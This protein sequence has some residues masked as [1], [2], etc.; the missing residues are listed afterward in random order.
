MKLSEQAI[1]HPRIIYVATLLVCMLSVLAMI[2][3]PVQR[4]P[5]ISKAVVLVAVP[6]PGAQPTEVEEQITRKIEETLQKLDRVDFVSS[7]SM[8]GSSVTQVVFLDGVD[9]EAA[10]GRV[11]DLVDEV[12]RELPGGRDVEP[13]VTDIDFENAPLMLVNMVPPEDFDERSLKLLAEEVQEELEAVEGVSSTQLFGGREREIHVDLNVDLAMEHGVAIQDVRNALAAYNSNL[14]G[15]SL[16]TGNVDFQVRSATKFRSLDDI[17]DAVVRSDAGRII[18][19]SDIASVTDTYR[20]L[21]NLAHLDGSDCATIIVY[22]ESDINT[23]QTAKAVK[24]RVE[25]LKSQYPQLQFSTTRDTSEEI[26]VMF[27]V[28]GSSFVF[29]AMLV[30][31][32]LGWAM[33]LRMS[34]LVLT[35]VPLSSGIALI[36][37]FA[38][39]IPISNMVIFSFI[40]VLG[41]VVDGAI[42][43]AENIHRH[44]EL[45]KT[46]EEAAKCG[47]QEVGLPVIMADLTTVAA[48]LPMLLV[49][50][51]MGDFM[52]VMPK[53]VSVALL[54]SV[55]V[56]HFLIPVLAAR[57]FSKRKAPAEARET[58][59]EPS[60]S[61]ADASG[62]DRIRNPLVRGYAT[63]LRWSLNN[64]WA[65]VA[66]TALAVVWAGFMLQR[67][68]FEFFPPSDRGQFEV[69]Y[70]LPLGTSI[71]QTIAAEEV[72]IEPL[73]QMAARRF[74]D[75]AFRV[76]DRLLRRS[77]QP[78]GE[79]PRLWG[80]NSGP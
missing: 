1:D 32:I 67:I 52:G 13:V 27:R 77:R 62:E 72:I 26:S 66:C 2:F 31:V 22:K 46:P 34:L 23:L 40:L 38:L 11:K 15:G 69:K 19:I 30:L 64:A 70:E 24:A 9:A 29:G 74:G 71:Q 58:P 76:G 25:E 61:T 16:E 53:V 50:G 17:G 4:T 51:I 10:R 6:H 42:I 55:L 5:A 60:S 35:A 21:Q 45:G 56:D 47:I 79:R 63:L 20:R 65:I 73:R 7:S 8:R 49:P 43:V 57:M 80:R 36:F 78:V 68:G 39:G 75:R 12:R 59:A 48:Y 33:G 14:P 54:G 37:L 44:I 41:M 3:I 28:L 18:R